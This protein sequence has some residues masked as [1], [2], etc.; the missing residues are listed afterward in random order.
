LLALNNRTPYTADRTFVRDNTGAD[1]WIV[2]VKATY[3][4]SEDGALKLANKQLPINLV[5]EYW[6]EPGISSI[7]YECD[8]TLMKPSTDV[9]V[10]A[11]AHAPRGRAVTE[12]AVRLQ[13]LTIDKTLVVTGPR[14]FRRTLWGVK[15]EAAEP[16]TSLPIRYELTYGGM[17][18]ASE[19]PTKHRAEMRNP[20]GCGFARDAARL[21]N[22]PAPSILYPGGDP[23]KSTPAGYGAIASFWSPRIEL[24]GTYDDQWNK[25]QRPLLPIDWSEQSLLC[26]PADQRIDGYLRG[27]EAIELANMSPHGV[28]RFQVPRVVLGFNTHFG[29]TI[30]AHRGQLVTVIIE[31]DNMRVILVW[32]TTLQVPLRMI[33]A[34]D[35]TDIYE[36]RVLT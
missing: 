11:T 9:L 3:A 8:L 4:M 34:L 24:A 12:L 23:T 27:G 31:P 20:I 30:K 21:E 2:G 5:A 33:D 1:H 7:R 25:D 13:V 29:S 32:Q 22:E 16:F 35:Q 36:K 28:I 14:R 26:A 18:L 10:N 6:G 17:D 19:D 15:A